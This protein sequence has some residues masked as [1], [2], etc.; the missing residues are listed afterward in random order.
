MTETAGRIL[1]GSLALERQLISEP[2]LDECEALQHQEG[3]GRS[4]QTILVE[5]GYLTAEQA[6]SLSLECETNRSSDSEMMYEKRKDILFAKLAV[7]YC[8]ATV[9]EVNSAIREQAHDEV[10][11][12]MAPLGQV[13]VRNRTLAAQQFV[14]IQ[15]EIESARLHCDQC[16]QRFPLWRF[17]SPATA[18]CPA[19]RRQLSLPAGELANLLG[20]QT[21][22]ADAPLGSGWQLGHAFD[23]D[24]VL[25][26]ED[27]TLPEQIGSFEVL[28]EI[29]RGGMG[30]LYRVRDPEDG[31]IYAI[32]QLK[33]SHRAH[34]R[35]IER[36]RSEAR[37][38]AMLV[39]PHIV[40]VHELG[41]SGRDYFLR[42]DFHSGTTLEQLLLLGRESREQLVQIFT[43]VV[44]AV[45]YAHQRGVIHRDLKPSNILIDHEHHPRL[46]DFGLARQLNPE[47]GEF[48]K[49]TQTGEAIGT[50]V[51]M[52][53]EQVLGNRDQID[54]R[55]DVYALGVML[56]Q[57]LAGQPPFLGGST[58][59]VYA[60]IL[61]AELVP[62]SRH[63]PGVPRALESICLRAM[64]NA[65]E[66]RYASCDDLLADL[67]RHARGG[68]VALPAHVRSALLR[69]V[70][71]MI[72]PVV[73]LLIAGLLLTL[74]SNRLVA[75]P[76]L[77]ASGPVLN[78]R[79]AESLS[80][81]REGEFG[82]AIA[83]ARQARRDGAITGA[84]LH[85]IRSW[86]TERRRRSCQRLFRAGR[87]DQAYKLA[88]EQR[89]W[90]SELWPV[91]A[92]SSW[93]YLGP[94]YQRHHEFRE[95]RL[96][97]VMIWI[98][99]SNFPMGTK[100]PAAEARYWNA[101]K[102]FRH[103]PFVNEHPQHSVQLSGYF[104]ARHE[105]TRVQYRAFLDANS[106]WRKGQT[107][108]ARVD[109]TYL[110]DWKGM[111]FPPG[112]G[113][114]PVSS[115][116]WHAARAFARWVDLKLPTEAQWERAARGTDARRLPWGNS[117]SLLGRR[118]NFADNRL[119]HWA[120][121]KQMMQGQPRDFADRK[122]DDG[123]IMIAPIG[124]YP[125]G[126]SPCGALNMAGNVQ[127]WCRD[128]YDEKFY[129]QTPRGGWRDPF[130]NV[131]P[132]GGRRVVRGGSFVDPLGTC[133]SAYRMAFRPD[134]CQPVVGF[135]LVR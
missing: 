53:P 4:L 106:H 1:V 101:R 74:R 112:T 105:V 14:E 79:L 77:R 121:Y 119:R 63:R 33:D 43:R 125:A 29:A 34:P 28:D 69:R 64:A 10:R 127:E 117:L 62:P 54:A 13:L 98:P 118:L 37:S 72:L 132:S 85:W 7:R 32:K 46:T 70:A 120:G 6:Q 11:G 61:R 115:I 73:V 41:I 122:V 96:G 97:L 24:G 100:D 71:V 133:R 56:Y 116:S 99:K 15:Q 26:I 47:D 17:Q 12:R 129:R 113:P 40:R 86:A 20:Q 65:R 57:I 95:P 107:R 30:V 8:H 82:K 9:N 52:P 131:Q 108:P 78:P 27:Q 60:N 2:Q 102:L 25:H 126:A 92:P 81:V 109:E 22:A 35:Q 103:A 114:H 39:H 36:F 44:E 51:Y 110:H 91:S 80:L 49:L 128:W 48:S 45:G 3:F 84:Q 135:R 111:D 94:N 83:R 59:E 130:C 75:L 123:A 16:E 67:A 55:T 124:T 50:P 38:M 42:M 18:E 58:A 66:E 68:K 21:T 134:N 93:R 19:C 104:I 87:I 23:A 90:I 88:G 5:K 76:R 31:R 89:Q